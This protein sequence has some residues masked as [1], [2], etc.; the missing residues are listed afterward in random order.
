MEFKSI[1]AFL[2]I[3]WDYSLTILFKYVF[4][5]EKGTYTWRLAAT[6][7]FCELDPFFFTFGQIFVWNVETYL[8]F[9][10]NLHGE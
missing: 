5:F 10:L 4:L 1:L 9:L 3:S 7:L 2:V 6:F 8:D